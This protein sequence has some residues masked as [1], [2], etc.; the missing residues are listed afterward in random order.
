MS[1]I[2]AI[3]QHYSRLSSE[4]LFTTRDLLGYAPRA[5]I[6]NA[7]HTLVKYGELIR[8]A[9][10][11]FARPERT[12]VITISEIA[13]VKARSFGRVIISH[14]ADVACEL[15]LVGDDKRNPEPTFATNGRTSSFRFGPIRIHFK[16]TSPRQITLGESKE[17]RTIRGLCYMGK[18]R[19]KPEAVESAIDK[20][21]DAERVEAG[22]LCRF[23][24]TWLSQYFYPFYRRGHRIFNILFYNEQDSKST[25]DP[26]VK[27]PIAAYLI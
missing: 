17:G 4:M 11:V 15:G 8:V 10:G 6:D 24:P 1:A 3:R 21:S 27:E 22:S 20:L 18:E 25:D 9:R 5:A 16:G 14:A 7:T 23:M 26:F 12:S 19:L 2:D 13:S